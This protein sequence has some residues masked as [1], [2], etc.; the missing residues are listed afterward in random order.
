MH[1]WVRPCDVNKEE[2]KKKINKRIYWMHIVI[3]SENLWCVWSSKMEWEKIFRETLTVKWL[4]L[5]VNLIKI[6]RLINIEG[7]L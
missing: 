4:F 6:Q 7:N 5:K 1:F 3:N 2:M